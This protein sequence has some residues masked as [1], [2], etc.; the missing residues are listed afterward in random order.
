MAQKQAPQPAIYPKVDYSTYAV[1]PDQACKDYIVQQ[2]MMLIKD[3]KESL[4]FYTK[5][6]GMR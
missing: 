4:E 3:P 2:T 5:V 1:E 6:L